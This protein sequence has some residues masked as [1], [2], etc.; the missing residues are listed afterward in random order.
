MFIVFNGSTFTNQQKLH[1]YFSVLPSEASSIKHSTSLFV[2][3]TEENNQCCTDVH[4]Y[5]NDNTA[6]K[7]P[8][9]ALYAFDFYLSLKV[10]LGIKKGLLGSKEKKFGL[11]FGKSREV[12]S[13]LTWG[14]AHVFG[15]VVFKKQ[16]SQL[17]GGFTV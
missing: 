8:V 12:L 5:S 16:S 3:R 2:L 11:C 4:S 1:I 7:L 14:A 10:P 17:R 13:L 15:V 9:S 6:A